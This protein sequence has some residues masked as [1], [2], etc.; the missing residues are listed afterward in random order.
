MKYHT[1]KS[2][3]AEAFYKVISETAIKFIPKDKSKSLSFIDLGCG[4]GNLC[5]YI[6]RYYKN[7]EYNLN[8]IHFFGIDINESQINIAK[9]LSN[10]N[11]HLNAK[12]MIEDVSV[13]YQNNYS[14]LHNKFDVVLSFWLLNKASNNIIFENMIHSMSK[15]LKYDG[16]IIG[17]TATYNNNVYTNKNKD[18]L[19]EIGF[20]SEIPN[21]FNMTINGLIDIKDGNIFTRKQFLPNNKILTFDNYFRYKNSYNK[22]AMKYGFKNGFEWLNRNEY[23]IPNELT[24]TQ[25][26]MAKTYLSLPFP[27]SFFTLKKHLI[28]S[29]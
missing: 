29:V 28:L 13:L 12:F 8:N 17:I 3:F 25:K 22:I 26:N 24:D 5:H 15:L 10:N 9:E 4:D 6:I 19:K 14:N 16:I 11:K 21:E 23:Y 27:F 1:T 20:E 18:K 2:E 7:N